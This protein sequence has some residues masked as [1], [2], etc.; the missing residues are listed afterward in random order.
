VRKA[1]GSIQKRLRSASLITASSG[2]REIAAKSADAAAVAPLGDAC[3]HAA[4]GPTNHNSRPK[5]HAAN[6]IRGLLPH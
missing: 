2:E 5:H 3:P 4:P 1:V 6:L